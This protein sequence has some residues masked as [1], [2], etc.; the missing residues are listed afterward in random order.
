MKFNW[1]YLWIVP[2][3]FMVGIE[4]IPDE[5]LALNNDESGFIVDLGVIRFFL[6]W[7]KE[8]PSEEGFS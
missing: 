2:H 5:L 6:T 8:K 7:T 4:L 1:W 3:G